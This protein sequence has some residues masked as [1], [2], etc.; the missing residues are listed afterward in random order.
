[1]KLCISK[2][3]LG[4]YRIEILDE[5]NQVLNGTDGGLALIMMWIGKYFAAPE[6]QQYQLDQRKSSDEIGV[7][8]INSIL[9]NASP[10]QREAF[11]ELERKRAAKHR[12]ALED[13]IKDKTNR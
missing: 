7:D 8:A 9:S 13:F 3:H 5:N 10:G 1:M 2:I 6:H 11:L 4:R 12:T